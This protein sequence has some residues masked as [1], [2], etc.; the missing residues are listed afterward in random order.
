M[1]DLKFVRAIGHALQDFLISKFELGTLAGNARCAAYL[2]EDEDI[3]AKRE[4]LI[5]RRKRLE[6]VQIELGNFGV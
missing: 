5:G 4:E 6:K 1:I 2:Q 3:V